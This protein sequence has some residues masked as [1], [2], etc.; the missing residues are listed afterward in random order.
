M[1]EESL[2]APTAPNDK[3]IELGNSFWH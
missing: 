1:S 3:Y 2:F